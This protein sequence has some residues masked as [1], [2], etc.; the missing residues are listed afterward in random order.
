MVP[1]NL[2]WVFAS[3]TWLKTYFPTAPVAFP[4][5]GSMTAPLLSWHPPPSPSWFFVLVSLGLPWFCLDWDLQ[6]TSAYLKKAY[7]QIL[8]FT[9]TAGRL[10][11]MSCRIGCCHLPGEIP[12]SS[13]FRC[14]RSEA[15][16]I[17][18]TGASQMALHWGKKLLVYS[19]DK[20]DEP[21][22]LEASR[23]GFLVWKS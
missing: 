14:R 12:C 10:Q 22:L 15:R 19:R 8:P 5:V 3:V 2:A 17:S 23:A 21:H 7:R 16:R 1:T 9:F 20:G 13:R 6:S 4:K 11:G 18:R